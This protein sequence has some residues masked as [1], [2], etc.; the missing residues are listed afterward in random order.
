MIAALNQVISKHSRWGFWKCFRCLRLQG[1]G[2]NHKRVYRVYCT[3]KLNLPRRTKKRL[4]QRRKVSLSVVPQSNWMWSIDF[5]HDSLMNGRRFRTLN[6]L[7]EGVRECLSIEVDTSL[8]SARVVRALEQLKSWRG[9][10]KQLRVDNG[11]EFI[12]STLVSWC[13]S[14]GVELNY[15]Q[16]G[17]PTQNA[18]IERFNRTFRYEL[19]DAYLFET[20]D[21]VREMS[22]Q[23]M[24][25]YNEERP[26]EALGN[27][28]PAMFNKLTQARNSTYELSA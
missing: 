12:S 18:F 23:W 17:K 26:H 10:P 15:I 14:N 11:P 9:V 3:L 5:M 28:P 6:I 1:Y 22:W 4:P 16:P 19:L 7:D 8:P 25:Q 24:R 20:L 21:Q 13:D 2:W 27:M